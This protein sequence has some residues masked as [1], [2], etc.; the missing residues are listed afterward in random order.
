MSHKKAAHEWAALESALMDNSPPCAGD[1]RF[2]L[3]DPP[4]ALAVICRRCPIRVACRV[5]AV[6]ARPEAGYWAGRHYGNV[7]RE[8]PKR[9]EGNAA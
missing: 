2:T 7:S 4:D 9:K 5:Y 6:K 3:D 1:A 8:T